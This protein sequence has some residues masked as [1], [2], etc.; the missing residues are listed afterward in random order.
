MAHFGKAWHLDVMKWYPLMKFLSRLAQESQLLWHREVM[1]L[2]ELWFSFDL[3]D[4]R[5]LQN[6]IKAVETREFFKEEK[7]ENLK[8][9]ERRQ[10]EPKNVLRCSLEVNATLMKYWKKHIVWGKLRLCQCKGLISSSGALPQGCYRARITTMALQVWAN[11]SSE[12]FTPLYRNY[13][14]LGTLL[15]NCWSCHTCRTKEKLTQSYHC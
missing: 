13:L 6:C 15:N 10:K 1:S 12:L 2:W 11:M 7:N 3:V 5:A 9:T 14:L 4:W 8:F